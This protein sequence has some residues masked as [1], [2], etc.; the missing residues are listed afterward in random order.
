MTSP[1]TIVKEMAWG[2]EWL[3]HFKLITLNLQ[4]FNITCTPSTDLC[5]AF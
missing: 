2:L 4:R 1:K 3:G 5:K